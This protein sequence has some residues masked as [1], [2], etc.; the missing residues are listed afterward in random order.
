MNMY[1]C[2]T[3]I[4]ASAWISAIIF[5]PAPRFKY[6]NTKTQ[7]IDST[8]NCGPFESNHVLSPIEEVKLI[9]ARDSIMS[10]LSFTILL[11][12]SIYLILYFIG[13]NS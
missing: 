8:H 4:I 11:Q 5:F 7:T 13:Y 2:F 9:P 3:F 6:L 1:V 12:V 10:R